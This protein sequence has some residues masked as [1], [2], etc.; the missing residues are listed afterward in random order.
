MS[1]GDP[2][3]DPAAMHALDRAL[4]HA[5]ESGDESGLTILGYG[6]ISCVLAGEGTAGAFAAKA[7]P[8]FPGDA[9][10]ERYRT[11]FRQ[12]LAGLRDR[13]I[14]PAPSV[15]HVEHR[16]ERP[17]VWCIQPRLD[18]SAL[19]PEVLRRSDRHRGMGIFRSLLDLL[20]GAVDPYFGVDGQLSNWALLDDELAYLDVTTPLLRGSDGREL[21]D[22]ELFL[23]SLPWA[24]RPLV[25][26]FA[27]HAVVDKYYDPRGVVVDLLGNMMKE[28]LEGLVPPFVEE[29]SAR[30]PVPITTDEVRHYYEADARMWEAMQRLRRMDRT[31][32]RKIRRR[33][34]PFLLPGPIRR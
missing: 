24:L 3:V 32:Q 26:R 30:L 18:P 13:H 29:A 27:L 10:V 8:P 28:R 1:S 5:L 31:W 17:V 15:L 25:R 11:I 21:L 19:L 12:Y 4:V 2:P 7:L 34:Y 14:H 6:E 33:P 22:T 23:A 16:G 20:L 9:H